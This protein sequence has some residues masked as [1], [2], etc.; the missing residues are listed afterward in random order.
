MNFDPA[1]LLLLLQMTD[2]A[3][4]TG[5]F[6][7]SGALET[8]AQ[9]ELIRTP[10]ELVELI[11]V[12]LASAARTDLI[13]VHS[14]LRAHAAADYAQ[15]AELD[16]LCSAS[17]LARETREASERIGRRMLASVLNLLDDALL[18]YYQDQITAGQ[19]AGH[20]AVVHGLACGALGIDPRAALL[21]FAYA[22]AANQTAS[23]LKLI[24]IGQTQAQAVLAT[25][26]A[27]IDAAVT[28]ALSYTLDDFGSFTPA[29][30]IRSTEHERLFRRLFIS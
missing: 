3:F 14:A 1:Q 13:V 17:K 5:A 12:K 2:S 29:L 15:I 28:E 26:G 11:V 19:A 27:A 21:A 16:A 20:Y 4:P 25:C 24:R 9:L 7:H 30:D 8:Y 6:A 22:L 23:S 18:G 10:D